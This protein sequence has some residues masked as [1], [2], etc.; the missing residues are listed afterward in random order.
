MSSTPR[1]RG[2]ARPRGDVD[3]RPDVGRDSS[4]A[5]PTPLLDLDVNID[6]AL[7]VAAPIN[8]A[9]AANANAA[10]PI[11]AAVSANVLSP[12]AESLATADQETPLSQTLDAARSRTRPGLVIEQGE[13]GRGPGDRPPDP[14]ATARRAAR[15][16][17][18]RRPRPRRR[19]AD[20]R[21]RRGQR[22]R[23]GA[24]RRRG[25][26]EHPVARTRRRS[27][28]RTRTRRSSRTSTA[29]RGR[30][31]PDL[32]RS[33]R[34][35][36]SGSWR[37]PPSGGVSDHRGHRRRAARWRGRP[38]RAAARRRRRAARRVRGLRASRSPPHLAR[39]ADGQVIQLTAA[40][41]PRRRGRRRR[42]ATRRRSPTSSP[43]ASGGG[44]SAD[45]VDVP[46]RGEAAPARRAGGRRRLARRELEKA[47]PLLA[48]RHRT[49]LVPSA[50]VQRVARVFAPLHSA[51]RAGPL[52]L[53]GAGRASTSGCSSR[54]A[55]PA[56][57]AA[58]S[59]SRCCCSAL[60]GAV[61]V[62]TAFHEIGHATRLPLRRRAPGRAR[63]RRLPR[64]AGVLLRRHRRLPAQPRGPAADR[65]R[66]RLLQRALR[67]AARAASTS[68]RASSRSCW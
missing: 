26:R 47:D 54:T 27:R 3:A 6:A 14:A 39:R 43:R 44:V 33:S 10:L 23:R 38:S 45:N 24:D 52:L 30:R 53:G 25:Q 4:T 22:E 61:I 46:R 42:S 1:R 55:S 62:A 37:R 64:L 31:R 40:A 59:T 49:A 28:A 36:R 50:A 13:A 16:R 20:Q 9:V 51:A 29:R 41:A 8:A 2:A 56:A 5:S 68:R 15:P 63:R 48:L 65:P 18:Q 11:D 67:A 21:G 34:A 17:R 12:D 58:R 66:R 7:D 19:G 57:C 35:R 32:H 60:F